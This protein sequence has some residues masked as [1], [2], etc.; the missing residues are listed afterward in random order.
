MTKTLLF[1]TMV[2]I[3]IMVVDCAML[4][5]TVWLAAA[6]RAAVSILAMLIRVTGVW[7]IIGGGVFYALVRGDNSVAERTAL[8]VVKFGCM[9]LIAGIAMH[10]LDAPEWAYMAVLQANM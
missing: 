5:P 1:V 7:A 8:I 2:L 9:A 10:V 6:A 3:G 4:M